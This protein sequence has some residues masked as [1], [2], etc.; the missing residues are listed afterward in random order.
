MPGAFVSFIVM[1]RI[2][3]VEDESLVAGAIQ[4]RLTRLGAGAVG[5]VATGAPAVAW[6]SRTRPDLVLMDIHLKGSLDGIDAAGE[7]YRELGTPV[8]YLTAYSDRATLDRARTIAQ[9]G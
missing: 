6:A 9:F 8:V 4:E 2:L 5:V 7:I 3:V 1:P